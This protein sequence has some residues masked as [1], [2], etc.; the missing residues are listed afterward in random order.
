MGCILRKEATCSQISKNT[1][2]PR[3]WGRFELFKHKGKQ[4]FFHSPK[5]MH[6]TKVSI[7]ITFTAIFIYVLEFCPEFCPDVF[8]ILG[9][10]IHTCSH[11]SP[12]MC[13]HM[14]TRAHTHTNT[15]PIPALGTHIFSYCSTQSVLE[16]G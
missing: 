12:C 7:I 8:P 10:H 2:L 9:V 6:K 3:E 11:T 15:S 16:L 13:M 4:I 14:C 1:I 5:C